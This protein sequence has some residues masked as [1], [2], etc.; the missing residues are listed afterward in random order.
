[1]VRQQTFDMLTVARGLVAAGLSVIPIAPG[2]KEPAASLL[3]R[4]L[5]E[6]SGDYRP[7]WKEY[8]QRLPNDRELAR[9]FG[10]GRCGLA[11]VT[12]A[13]SGGLLVL[14]FD[15][16]DAF[17]QWRATVAQLDPDLLGPLVLVRSANGVH[18]YWRMPEAPPNRKLARRDGKTIAE[19]R[20]EGGYV[21]APP[22]RHP[23]GPAYQLEQGSLAE[24]PLLR[25]DQALLLLNVAR[26]LQ[27]ES[28]GGAA[29]DG[30]AGANDVIGAFNRARTVEAVLEAHGY[31]CERPGRYIRPGGQRSSVL[32]SDGRS[33]H[34]NSNDPLYSEAPGGGMRRHTAFSAWCQ[35]E[36]GGDL[37]AAVK[38]AAAEL[39]LTRAPSDREL[40]S[41]AG[42]ALGLGAAAAVD[43]AEGAEGAAWPYFIHDGGLWMQRSD[44]DGSPR[45]PIVLT[46][47]TARIVAETLIDDGDEQNE[48]Y[49]I[50]AHCGAR[51]RRLEMRRGDF[52]GEGALARIVAALGARARVNPL[53]QNRVVLDAIKAFSQQVAEATVYTHTGWI[54]GGRYLLSNGYVDAEGWHPSLK[55][56]LPEHLQRYQLRPAGELGLALALFDRLLE[57]APA[58][59]MVPLLGG[60]LLAPVAH[61]IDAPAPMVHIYGQT[62]SRKTSICCAALALWGQ[63]LPASPTDSWTSTSNS[64]QRLGWHLKDAPMLLDDYKLA[65]VRPKDVTFL[66]QNYGDNMARGRLDGNSEL[67][68]VYPVRA[69]LISSGEDQPEGEAAVLARILSVPVKRTC[70]HLGHLSALQEQPHGLHPLTAAYL[71]WLAGRPACLEGNAAALR[72]IRATVLHK[73]EQAQEH[74]ANPGRVASN[75]AALYVAWETFSAFLV[76]RGLWSAERRDAWLAT[77][78]RELFSLAR[79]QVE[80]TTQERYSQVF[81]ETLRGLIAGGRAMLL[82]LEGGAQEQLSTQM[83]VGGYD[84]QGTYLICSAAYDLVAAHLRGTGHPVGF[85]GR[86]LAQMLDAEGLLLSRQE[87][88]LGMQKRINKVQTFCWHLPPGILINA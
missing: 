54:R 87:G 77:C 85:T 39:G 53:A 12:G 16:P 34:F 70:V 83:L 35:L 23:S 51:T 56:Q 1:M 71:Q 68:R 64:T 60:V 75:V 52:E 26:A 37:K 17:E 32:I 45:A 74:A 73:L 28:P 29:G 8:Q 57:L 88:R 36:H 80:L 42:R 6:A 18:V 7:S 59:V 72:G 4:H 50:E 22:S 10:E 65:N 84:R 46:N 86:A 14:D 20:G 24:I 66:L 38:T 43:S 40:L 55:C 2:T 21:L 67:T 27:P 79:S 61:T 82:D 78:K 69:I 31:T 76:A 48:S 19:T 81:L 25:P 33:T 11:I 62:G 5:D 58:A 9:W 47:F 15:Q 3:P 44:K 41:Q 63:F 49:T 30:P 13:V